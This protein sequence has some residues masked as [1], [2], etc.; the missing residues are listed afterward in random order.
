MPTLDNPRLTNRLLLI[1]V[2]FV[3]IAA[4]KLA[5]PVFIPLL[6]TVL[7]VYVMDPI[8]SF[9]HGRKIPLWISTLA[10]VLLVLGVFFCISLLLRRDF[11][12]F[13]KDFPSFQEE[14]FRRAERILDD[15]ERALGAG[16]EASP[17]GDLRILPVGQGLLSAAGS[18]ARALSEFVL[19]IFFATI[20]LMGKHTVVDRI[21]AAFPQKKSMV[22]VILRHIDSH[23]RIF[24]GIKALSSLAVG[25][26]TALVLAAF[27]VEFAV[28]WGFLAF[29]FNFVP[30]LGPIASIAAPVLIAMVQYPTL[31]EPLLAA[32]ILIVLHLGVSSLVEP[33][34]MGQHLNLSFFVIFLSLFFWGWVWGPAGVLLAVPVTTSIKIILER[35]P[36]T[37]HFALLLEGRHGK[38]PILSRKGKAGPG[39]TAAPEGGG[40]ERP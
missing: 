31:L 2:I 19:I 33:R 38:K 22:P 1:I 15:V 40:R 4:L 18:A 8:V 24:L 12:H 34:F 21:L 10:A 3:C 17:L 13:A 26:G 25:L 39:D 23:L 27:R 30:T 16:P 11:S 32:G 35:I 29:L 9:L 20:L 5:A 28:T 36:A 7:L 6:L 37:S 14:I